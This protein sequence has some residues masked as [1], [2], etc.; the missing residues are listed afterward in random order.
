MCRFV[1]TTCLLA[2]S[3]LHNCKS[4]EYNTARC[5]VHRV[6]LARTSGALAGLGFRR[7][8]V[9]ALAFN[10]VA[11]RARFTTS[12]CTRCSPPKRTAPMPGPC[13]STK[14]RDGKKHKRATRVLVDRVN[15]S[16]A[17]SGSA[18][19]TLSTPNST[20]AFNA[21]GTAPPHSAPIEL[22]PRFVSES[23]R[24]LTECRPPEGTPYIY[25]HDPGNGP[26]VRDTRA[27]LSSY[28]AH[29]PSLD[30]PLCAEFAQEEVLQMLMTVLPKDIAL[31][32]NPFSFPQESV[33]IHAYSMQVLW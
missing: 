26:R 29:P 25:I 13:T 28:F 5:H 12:V 16:A 8:E 17:Q 24:K 10:A 30:D 19:L 11:R 3:F 32:R 4:G 20:V 6:G 14:T 27:F 1:G 9:P 15:N 22:P 2:L 23:P 18:P 21:V 31:V 7:F 33:T